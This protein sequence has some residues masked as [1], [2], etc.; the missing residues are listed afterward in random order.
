MSDFSGKNSKNRQSDMHA[1]VP[2]LHGNTL[3]KYVYFR[4]KTWSFR[5]FF[6][7]LSNLVNHYFIHYSKGYDILAI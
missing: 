3:L 1:F 5:I 2:L 6:S 7:Y 4:N